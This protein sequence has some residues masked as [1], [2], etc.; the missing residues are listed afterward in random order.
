MQIEITYKYM[1]LTYKATFRP[2]RRKYKETG[3]LIGKSI[4][5]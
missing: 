4:A 2:E 1:A 3:E 5:R